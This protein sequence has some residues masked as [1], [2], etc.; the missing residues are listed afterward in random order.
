M[1]KELISSMIDGNGSLGYRPSVSWHRRLLTIGI[2]VIA[3]GKR[4]GMW[5]M[6]YGPRH[7]MVEATLNT[8][9]MVGFP[10]WIRCVDDTPLWSSNHCRSFF[11][12]QAMQLKFVIRPY[13]YMGDMGLIGESG[14][15]GKGRFVID[16]YIL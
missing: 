5:R 10:A 1:T 15:I 11:M 4:R 13:R 14:L 2:R 16:M 8:T 3:V 9:L 6:S 12:L 7:S